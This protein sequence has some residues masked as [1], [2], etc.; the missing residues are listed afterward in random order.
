MKAVFRLIVKIVLVIVAESLCKYRHL[1]L[2]AKVYLFTQLM[3]CVKV[4]DFYVKYKNL[5]KLSTN[6]Y[7]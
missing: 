2:H 5:Y 7:L 6:I 3:I 1:I 4:F